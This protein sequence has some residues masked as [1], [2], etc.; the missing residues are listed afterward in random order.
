MKDDNLNLDETVMQVTSEDPDSITCTRSDYT[1][2]IIGYRLNRSILNRANA[3]Y[4]EVE[5][6]FTL[7]KPDTVT[8]QLQFRPTKKMWPGLHEVIIMARYKGYDRIGVSVPKTTLLYY[9]RQYDNECRVDLGQTQTKFNSFMASN[10]F[11]T[12]KLT[13]GDNGAYSEGRYGPLLTTSN[14]I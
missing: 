8:T 7:A 5:K 14:F 4:N 6:F 13:L 12:V 1:F 3:Y 2:S 11:S 10:P 9:D